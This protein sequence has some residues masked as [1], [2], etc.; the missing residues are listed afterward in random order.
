MI[1]LSCVLL[2]SGCI[3][4]EQADARIA[5]GCAA[6][7]ELFLDEGFTIKETKNKTYSTPTEF[8]TGYRQVTISAVETDNWLE[9]DKEYRCIFAEE[10]GPLKSSHNTTIYQVKVNDKT[11]GRE[12]N[13]II[14]FRNHCL[15]IL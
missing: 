11:Y 2:L 12:G 14:T 10:F 5:K 1:G 9:L 13:K 3:S 8:G 7:V 15:L 6:A 4:R